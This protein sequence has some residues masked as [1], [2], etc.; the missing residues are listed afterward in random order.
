MMAGGEVS[1][2]NVNAEMQQLLRMA[3]Q[4]ASRE[5]RIISEA[6]LIADRTPHSP[7]NKSRHDIK[8]L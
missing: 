3:S 1:G 6:N 5:R 7:A 4:S 8:K 2:V